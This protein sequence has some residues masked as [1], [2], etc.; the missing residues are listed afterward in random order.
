MLGVAVPDCG[1]MQP[2]RPC[3]SALRALVPLCCMRLCQYAARA[4]AS[5]LFTLVPV[6][7]TRLCMQYGSS[8][9]PG[10]MHEA[11]D[12]EVLP[13]ELDWRAK[14]AVSGVKN[15][16]QV[17]PC[18]RELCTESILGWGGRGPCTALISFLPETV[19]S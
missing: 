6:C 2:A 10:F 16:G 17:G 9:I 11:T 4:C 7:R 1:I 12:T 19:R 15:Q 13:N 5:A 18:V 8:L 14:G 3:A